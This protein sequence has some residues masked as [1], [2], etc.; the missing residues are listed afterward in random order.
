MRFT[1]VINFSPSCSTVAYC[2]GQKESEV[3]HA[4][5]G[6]L[7]P[8]LMFLCSGVKLVMLLCFKLVCKCKQRQLIQCYMTVV[9]LLLVA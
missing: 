5:N 7:H 3:L 4:E 1:G 6:Y 9:A 8:K 2:K